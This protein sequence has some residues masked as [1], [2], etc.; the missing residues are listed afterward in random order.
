ME[1]IR[2]IIIT[3]PPEHIQTEINNLRTPLCKQ[4][5]SFQALTYPP[6]VTLRTGAIVPLEHI[7]TY[8]QDFETLLAEQKPFSIESGE[9][10]Y[11]S[12]FQ[13]DIK[14]YYIF[15][16]I[17]LSEELAAL[18]KKLLT[19]KSY[20]KSNKTTFHPHLTL[21]FD[22]LEETRYKELVSRI[23]SNSIYLSKKFKWICNN[24]CLYHFSQS[25]WVPY[26]SFTF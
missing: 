6:H 9:I 15:Y 8:I 16:K 25:K 20:I 22:D 1:K 18:N 17:N 4:S 23:E 2:F 26:H 10:D 5:N 13:N 19:F 3:L 7:T 14:K 12:Y 24:V 21:V 11:G